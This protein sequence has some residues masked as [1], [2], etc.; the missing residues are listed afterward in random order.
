M[1]DER[2]GK[3]EN[4]Y[5]IT[6]NEELLLPK[7]HGD[8]NKMF[9]CGIIEKE[10]EYSHEI[11][12]ERFYRTEIRI[13]RKSGIEDI[14]SVIVSEMLVEEYLDVSVKG[15][16]I[17]ASG[18]FRSYNRVDNSGCH[19]DLFLY[20]TSLKIY[21]ADEKNKEFFHRNIIYFNGFICRKPVFRITP[22][23]RKIADLFIA[24]NR[25]HGK[26]D[27][28][29]CIVWEKGALW[30]KKFD[31]GDQVIIYGRV[32]SRKYF[33]KDSPESDT[34]VWKQVNEVCVV[35]I[36]KVKNTPI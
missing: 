27:Y 17:D 9:A 7:E 14:V 23:G 2:W 3:R 31:I 19:L 30:A 1:T 33:K 18:H 6:A 5:E 10:F 34:G 35:R 29:P 26:T 22:L 21:D 25:K 12:W 4:N 13:K 15:K 32:Q 16:V 8:F 20:A 24:A 28:I 11:A 36:Q